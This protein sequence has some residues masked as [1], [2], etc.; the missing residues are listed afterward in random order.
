MTTKAAPKPAATSA[1]P[2]AP[3]YGGTTPVTNTGADPATGQTSSSTD[4][5]PGPATTG[6]T[7]QTTAVQ[8][9]A[10]VFPK[11]P[12][13]LANATF[14][15]QLPG[16]PATPAGKYKGAKNGD[17]T[18]LSDLVKIVHAISTGDLSN[19]GNINAVA[20]ADVLKNAKAPSDLDAKSIIDGVEDNVPLT[21]AVQ[22]QL[23][24]AAWKGVV[25]H[26]GTK[27]IPPSLKAPPDPAEAEETLQK[28]GNIPVIQA[29]KDRLQRQGYDVS[30]INDIKDVIQA[31]DEFQAGAPGN[32]GTPAKAGGQGQLTGKAFYN[33]FMATYNPSSTYAND[34]QAAGFLDATNGT[35]TT[36]QV[37]QAIQKVMKVAQENDVSPETVLI[38]EVAS[39][40][41]F[42]LPTTNKSLDTSY[43]EHIA[44]QV[45]VQLS[46]QD[47][48]AISNRMQAL[49]ANASV[50]G[51]DQVVQE[52]TNA[53]AKQ[54]QENPGKAPGGWG[55]LAAENIRQA[56]S[57]EGVPVT[58]AQVNALVIG[59]L[60]SGVTSVYS[61]GDQATA[62][63][64]QAARNQAISTLPNLAPQLKQDI[65][66]KTLADPYLATASNVLGIAA[67]DM[68]PSSPEWQEWADGGP[69]GAQ[70]SQSAWAKHLMTDPKYGFIGSQTEKNVTSEGASGLLQMFGALPSGNPFSSSASTSTVS[71]SPS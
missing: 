17:L 33:Q 8:P 45:G 59:T 55:A 11:L 13:S 44:A 24:A 51:E 48:T 47:L 52:V 57:A 23:M 7:E 20:L 38:N 9:G 15:D 10:D 68:D 4:L 53:A 28:L 46:G 42:G 31:H 41:K 49:G 18:R 58:D 27:T 69:N 39:P 66:Y 21:P 37:G 40:G 63:A 70:M 14:N 19:F 34:L 25:A 67:A 43:V 2:G 61:A 54:L 36:A 32:P 3:G 12:N 50:T 30:G 22:S 1:V 35:P 29:T 26:V 6:G 64:Q 71:G 65:P 56:Y 16:T 62:L 60:K 5:G